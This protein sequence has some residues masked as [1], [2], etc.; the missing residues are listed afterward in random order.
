ME[1]LSVFVS[2]RRRKAP[3]WSEDSACLNAMCAPAPERLLS[4]KQTKG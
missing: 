2:E 1:L 3:T 4:K